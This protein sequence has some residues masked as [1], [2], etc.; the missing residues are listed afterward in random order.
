MRPVRIPRSG[1]AKRDR[2]TALELKSSDTL[3]WSAVDGTMAKFTIE[4]PDEME[5]IVN[6][7]QFDGMVREITCPPEAG[8]FKIA[9]NEKADFD[10][11]ADIWRWVNEK[12][13]NHFYLVVGA[14][15]CGFNKDRIVYNVTNLVY[16]DE[17]ET[18]VLE[19]KL[20][21]WKEAAHTFDLTVGRAALPPPSSSSTSAHHRRD[22][23]DFFDNVGDKFKD[24]GDKIV[25]GVE[26]IG[27]KIGD[28]LTIDE[29]PSFS[30]PLSAD[31][32]GSSLSFD[33]PGNKSMTASVT[34]VEC[35][36][37]GSLQVEGHFAAR[38]FDITAAS[39]RVS[40]PDEGLRATTLLELALT[41][42]LRQGV[43]RSVP[44]FKA[45]PSPLIIPQLMTIGPAV[46]LNLVGEIGAVQGTVA[47]TMGGRATV[48]GGSWAMLDFFDEK[49]TSKEG[50][51]VTFE[52]EQFA[53]KASIETTAGV[54]LRGSI[55]LEISVLGESCPKRK[56]KGHAR[57][58]KFDD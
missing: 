25:D 36:T 54:F 58:M 55:G 43:K 41:A 28:A 8:E 16:N 27:D 30:V 44:I 42:E 47:L 17:A 33:L 5:N 13:D 53:A 15:D 51:G 26:K 23:G 32:T 50:W 11:A 38:A 48:A 39:V 56:K 1:N 18:A 24:V 35:S 10:D 37:A 9:F 19:A 7:E 45:A 52:G 31:L 29:R 22:I 2:R 21:T 40:L 34:C 12:A 46:A 49:K 14:G 57:L 3:Y 4:L 20:T 6:L